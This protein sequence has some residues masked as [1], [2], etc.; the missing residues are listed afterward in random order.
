MKLDNNYYRTEGDVLNVTI[1]HYLFIVGHIMYQVQSSMLWVV[2][3]T[4]PR[5]CHH[6]HCHYQKSQYQIH[7]RRL[8]SSPSSDSIPL[9]NVYFA[10]S[11]ENRC[12]RDACGGGDGGG[13]W[14]LCGRQREMATH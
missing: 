14:W 10:T 9:C 3:C 1:Y 6:C 13:L 7:L 12:G 8:R 11:A 4:L 5:H 2:K